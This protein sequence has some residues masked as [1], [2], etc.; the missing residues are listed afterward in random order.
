MPLAGNLGEKRRLMSESPL[1]SDAGITGPTEL[2]WGP[3]WM[4][5]VQAGNSEAGPRPVLRCVPRQ[6]E[7]MRTCGLSSHPPFLPGSWCCPPTG[8]PSRAESQQRACL[9]Y[10]SLYRLGLRRSPSQGVTGDV[11]GR[12]EVGGVSSGAIRK[13][14]RLRS[15]NA[16]IYFLTVP[17]SKSL[18]PRRE[19]HGPLLSL[20]AWRAGD[21]FALT[22]RLC[23]GLRRSQ[24]PWP[25]QAHARPLRPQPPLQWPCVQTQ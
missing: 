12:G 6:R 24:T 5:Q 1:P 18:S 21:A 4:M 3:S 25:A 16:R 9:A 23:P 7:Q 8:P 13:Y 22:G 20:P 19:R 10:S 15:L 11:W 17:E 2:L 14:H